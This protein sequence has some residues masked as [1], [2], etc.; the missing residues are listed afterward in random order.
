[1]SEKEKNT[2][3]KHLNLAASIPL[4]ARTMGRAFGDF[5]ISKN[6]EHAFSRTHVILALKSYRAHIKKG[7]KVASD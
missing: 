6:E 3:F 4:I 2:T 7:L 5:S 1:M